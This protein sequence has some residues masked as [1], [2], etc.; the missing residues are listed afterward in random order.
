MQ[1]KHNVGTQTTALFSQSEMSQCYP[2][3]YKNFTIQDKSK[4]VDNIR[5]NIV[6][7]TTNKMIK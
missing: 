7:S 5:E 6:M 4:V 1:L 2:W 3:G